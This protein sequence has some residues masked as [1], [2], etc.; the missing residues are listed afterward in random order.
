MGNGVNVFVSK[1]EL[2]NNSIPKYKV[3]DY[4]IEFKY[5]ILGI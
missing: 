5:P 3:M 4:S 2:E 1:G